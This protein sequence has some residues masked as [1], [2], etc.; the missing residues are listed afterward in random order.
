MDFLS[1][2]QRQ[3]I[4]AGNAIKLFKLKDLATKSAAAAQ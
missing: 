4:F 2:K 3:D 1:E